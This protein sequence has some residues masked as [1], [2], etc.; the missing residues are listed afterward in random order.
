MPQDP[1]LDPAD[2]TALRALG[3]RMLDDAFAHLEH[4]GEGPV[5][6]RMPD[7]LRAALHTPAPRTPSDPAAVYEDFLRTIQP[8][9]T[10]NLH[11]GFMG[12][13]HGGGTPVGMLAELL[14]AGLNSNLGG[15]DQAPIEIERQVIR[16]SAELLGMPPETTGLLVTGTSLANLIAVLAARRAA[17]GPDVRTQGLAAAPLTAYAADG[18]HG[19]VARALDMAGLGTDALRLIPT[20]AAHRIDPAL[21]AARITEDR[22]AGLRPFLVVGNAGTVDVGAIDDLSALADLAQRED[23][24]FHVDGAFGAMA[25]LSPTLRPLLRGIERADS[26]AFDFHKWAQVPYDAGCVLVRRPGAQSDAFAQDLAYLHREDR[27]LAAGHPW[28]CDLGPD[29]S[30]GFRALKVWMT[31]RTYGADR[32]GEVI[33]RCCAV[34]R[35][36]GARVESEPRLELCAPVSLNVVCFR[37]RN[38]DDRLQADLAADVQESGDAVPSTTRIAGRTVLRA[39]VINHRTREADADRLVDAVLRAADARQA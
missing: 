38:G 30:R 4:L 24:W 32:L 34:A 31:L 33:E 22:A 36:L 2:W 10:G 37:L 23:L 8:Y 9:A 27:G 16:W 15:R 19:C 1:T 7:D 14:A 17:L 26:V 6:Q 29:L 13:V 39:C 3:H 21:L 35:H 28:P 20:D 18:V 25:A 5:W 11:P 12:W